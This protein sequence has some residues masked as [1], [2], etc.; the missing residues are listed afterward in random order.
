MRRKIYCEVEGKV[1]KAG[2][3][4]NKSPGLMEEKFGFYPVRIE[5]PLKE[6]MKRVSNIV[7]VMLQKD[8][9][10]CGTQHGD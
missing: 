10:H 7:S 1:G 3:D 9:F 8:H 6:L 2:S 5:E 4:K